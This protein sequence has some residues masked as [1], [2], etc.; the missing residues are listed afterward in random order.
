MQDL[1]I[2]L[3]QSKLHWHQP[4]ANRAMFE[5]KIWQI[6]YPTDI[7]VLPEM[8]TTGFTMDAR[9]W[10]EPMGTHTFR[11][12][13]QM[14]RQKET[15]LV[16]SYIVKDQGAFFNRLLW[17]NPDGSYEY[18]DKRHLFRMADEHDHYQPGASRLVVEYRG[19]KICPQIC[20]DLRF[21][22]WNR[23]TYD[24]Q[25]QTLEYDLLLF[26]ANWP[27]PRINAWDTLLQA[28]AIEN[29]CY[30]VG[31]NRIGKD[32]LGVE[33]NG[34]SGIVDPKGKFIAHLEDEET[35]ITETLDGE[36]MLKFREKFPV[37]LDADGFEILSDH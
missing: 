7:I 37:H 16:G 33:Y 9:S 21:P 11:W 2:T 6:N 4:E 15:A 20:Y 22:V 36:I 24:R 31:L 12:M 35:I 25:K 18:Y 1:T 5:E 30:A 10:A 27:V 3:I 29:M 23:N 17:M 32:G 28:R 34:H 13:S 19:W 8:F 14:A 26:V